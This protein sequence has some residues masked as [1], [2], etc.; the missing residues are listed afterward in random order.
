MGKIISILKKRVE[1]LTGDNKF[2]LRLGGLFITFTLVLISGF[3][4]WLIER[5]ALSISPFPQALGSI[6]IVIG[7]A[8]TIA[9]R[10][11]RDSILEVLRSLPKNDSNDSL[12][13]VRK[14]LSY[15]VGRDV[16]LLNKPEI[17]RAT[18]ETAS[19]NSVDG[20][21]APLFWMFVGAV[22]WNLSPDLPGPLT[23]SLIF[24][25]SSTLD[26]MIGY[27]HG[28]LK[29]LGTA[30]AKLDDVLT[31]L[32]CRMVLLTLPLVSQPIP[33]I[34]VLIRLA[35]NDGSKDSSPN[36]GISEAIFAH[37]A[38]VK[39]GGSNK[40]NQ[41]IVIKPILARDA[42]EANADSIKRILRLSLRLEVAWLA[43]IGIIALTLAVKGYQ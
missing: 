11:L 2:G 26:S 8:S 5:L 18:A 36:A 14:K 31:W 6:F 30:G 22:L 37:C 33:K 17:L 19:E 10:S 32:P 13:L 4:G 20:I 39:M 16:H 34:P 25:A 43:T 28:R 1:V 23:L 9:A 24:K 42:S 29:W 12:Q 21:F 7:L 35:W 40:Y 3:C 41:T 38:K 27:Q 15:I